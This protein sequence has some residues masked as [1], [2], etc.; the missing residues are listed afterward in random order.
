MDNAPLHHDKTRTLPE[1]QFED[2]ISKSANMVNTIKRGKFGRFSHD[3]IFIV[4][5]GNDPKKV[6]LGS[7]NFSVTGM[8]V[9]SNH[10]VIFNDVS[11]AQTYAAVFE[12]SWNDDVKMTFSNSLSATQIFSF[13]SDTVPKTNITFSPHQPTFALSNLKIISDRITAEKSSVLF[14]VMALDPG[15]GPILQALKDIHTNQNIFSYGISDSPGNGIALYKPGDSLG[16]LVSGKPGQTKLP[17]PFSQEEPIPGLGHQ[18]HH[19]FV[20]CDFNGSNAVTYCGSSN[21]A[22]GGEAAN[23]D[24][25]VAIYDQDI[26]T[27]F[28][29]EA[30]ALVDHFNFRDKFGS[31]NNPVAVQGNAVDTTTPKMATIDPGKTTDSGTNPMTLKQNDLWTKNY[32]DESDTHCKE[33]ILLS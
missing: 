20:I 13:G 10:V 33:R 2:L 29:I 16:I 28:A 25:L 7:T 17:P 9:N 27:V 8:Y 3:K 14:A 11:V 31:N 26:S 32:Y 21:L 19:K 18:I 23:G 24:N 15:T 1:D 30:F 5:D 4:S 22:Q 12:E 6:L